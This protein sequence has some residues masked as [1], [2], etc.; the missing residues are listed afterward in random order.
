M[1]RFEGLLLGMNNTYCGVSA[2]W[3]YLL[4][5]SFTQ[6]YYVATACHVYF[7]PGSGSAIGIW[8]AQTK[9]YPEILKER[10]HLGDLDADDYIVLK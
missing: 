6:R 4:L 1:Q 8:K 3:I 10:D 5:G 2:R 9:F 7:Y